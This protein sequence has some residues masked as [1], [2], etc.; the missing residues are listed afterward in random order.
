MGDAVRDTWNNERWVIDRL[1]DAVEAGDTDATRK[2]GQRLLDGIEN[3]NW[4]SFRFIEDGFFL[5]FRDLDPANLPT[6][7]LDCLCDEGIISK[8]RVPQVDS[9]APLDGQE[10]QAMA[11]DGRG[12]SIC[13][14]VRDLL[15][16]V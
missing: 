15:G 13:P 10:P 12:E 1:V 3:D 6:A 9:G 4:R 7:D 14:R 16:D 11:R 2:L 5:P 8:A